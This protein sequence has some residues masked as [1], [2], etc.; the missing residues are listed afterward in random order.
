MLMMRLAG[1]RLSSRPLLALRGRLGA[2]SVLGRRGLHL[3]VEA[4]PRRMTFVDPTVPEETPSREREEEQE[5]RSL[6]G[7][8]QAY[9]EAG[10][11]T[12]AEAYFAR[13]LARRRALHGS[14]DPR[15]LYAM[16]HLTAVLAARGSLHAA[17][18]LAKKQCAA[19]LRTLGP[20]HPD[21][22]LCHGHAVSLLSQV[23][24]HEEA[25]LRSTFLARS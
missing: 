24:R 3:G 20:C 13:V 16:G 14:D 19:S 22:L 5:L 12:R 10:D 2:A 18:T 17:V 7:M 1:S 23:G 21:T 4:D 25:P 9:R 6:N 15:T 8:A 11:L